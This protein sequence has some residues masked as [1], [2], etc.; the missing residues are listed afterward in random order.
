ML[1]LL[2]EFGQGGAAVLLGIATGAGYVAAVIAP[3]CFFDG[4]DAGRA[5][6][7][8]RNLLK[9]VST[10]NVFLLLAAGAF[11]VLGGAYGAAICAF[12]GALGFFANG[13]TLRGY[14]RGEVPQ[15]V[16]RRRKTQRVVAVSLTLMFTLLTGIGAGLAAFGI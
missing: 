10:P 13:W 15:G 16:K 3:N 11:A 14:K 12:L 5:D 8:V 4:L 7:Q 9:S 2:R 6:R 1:D